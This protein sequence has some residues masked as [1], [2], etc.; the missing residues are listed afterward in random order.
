MGEFYDA[1]KEMPGWSSPGFDD[2]KWQPAVCKTGSNAKIEPHPGN[3]VQPIEQI[4][5]KSVR[6]HA[7]GVHIFDLGQNISG[8]IRLKVKGKAGDK[9][10]I[11]YAEV[12][13]N[14]GRL[15]TENLR[16]ARAVDTYI[17]KG[18]PNG[19]AWTPE[20]T[21]HGFQYVELTGF[22]GTPD[23]NA[24][25]GIVLHSDT[26]LHG[27]FKC[28]DPMLN[29][30]HSNMVWT[31]RGN[32]FEMPTDCP[33]R[34]ERMGWTGDAQIYV[35]AATFNADIAAFYTK[36]LRD[37]NDDQWDYGAY[38]AYAP[39]PLARP[40]E[41][42]AAGWMDA[43]VI[44]PWTIWQVYGDTRVIREHWR[45]MNDFMA[46]RATRDPELKGALDDCNFGDWLSLGDVKTPIP[47]IDLAY[48][49][50][51]A[52]LMAEMAAAI[53]DKAA[54]NKYKA[55]AAKVAAAFQKA[56]L[57]PDAKLAVHNQST[58]A[59]ALFFDLIPAA[60]K[61]AAAGHL[62]ALVKANGN[63][64][65]TGFL[66]TRPLLPALSATGHHD[67]AG[68]LMQQREFP[69]WGYEVDNGATTIW[70]RWNS[71]I[72]GKGV[73]EPT[74]N[75]F[76]HYAFGA[77]CEWMFADLAGIDRAAPGF[78]KVKIAP[79]PT[80][81]I[82]HASAGMDTRHG[83]LSCSWKIENSTFTADVV[84]PP[85]TTAEITLP[86]KPEIRS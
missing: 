50:Y 35:R 83:A 23:K 57:K 39:R 7:P 71:Y 85:N 82:T 45:K 14:D 62:A 77:V 20:F 34:D 54:S 58:Y 55:Q 12:L 29:Q 16:C 22:P 15:S 2:S 44:C 38:P 61:D 78:D 51:D 19:E 10:T 56:Y 84:V 46:W 17:L 69:S 60:Q 76:S 25:T 80:G 81:T 70:E 13:H 64:M 21:Y 40:N 63:K 3:P 4:V 66:G 48:H 37:L 72:K 5:P 49:A 53:G 8:V 43:G 59:M 28:S 79:R 6:E 42:H 41:H 33:Q 32:F 27:K 26:P 75:S 47:F 18:D 74:M 86:V 11:R 73:H 9:V 1:R 24:V 30:L 31:Q 36:W 65:T 68:I 67:L 52:R